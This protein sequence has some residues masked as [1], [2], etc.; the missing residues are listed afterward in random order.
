MEN[1]M[2]WDDFVV[3]VLF[4]LAAAAEYLGWLA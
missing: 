3:P 4:A 1:A 2:R